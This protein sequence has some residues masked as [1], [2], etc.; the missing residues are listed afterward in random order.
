VKCSSCWQRFSFDPKDVTLDE[1]RQMRVVFLRGEHWHTLCAG[2]R[3]TPDG[4]VDVDPRD[5]RG[6]LVKEE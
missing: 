5:T 3:R 2:I 6:R 1:L 4:G